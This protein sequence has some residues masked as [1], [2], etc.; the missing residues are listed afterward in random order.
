MAAQGKRFLQRRSGLSRRNAQLALG[1][2]ASAHPRGNNA[3]LLRP[4][5][6][7]RPIA[8]KS[9]WLSDARLTAAIV[10][11]R[12]GPKIVVVLTYRPELSP[13]DALAL[14][15]RVVRVVRP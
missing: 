4:F 7:R 3:G 9:G 14:G 5:L 8:Q 10:Y 2:L 1:L 13:R 15:R 6:P 11:G 12:R